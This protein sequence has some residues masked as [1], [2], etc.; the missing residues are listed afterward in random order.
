M[1]IADCPGAA[2]RHIL[3]SLRE[4]QSDGKR[5]G[6]IAVSSITATANIGSITADASVDCGGDITVTN[7]S[8]STGYI[9]DVTAAAA[10][11]ANISAKLSL[12]AVRAGIS[13]AGDSLCSP[14][15][16]KQRA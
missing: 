15:G 4:T 6:R 7:I 13:Q 5:Y 14:P 8:T 16:H 9:G 11:S 2:W 12:G 1:L 10:L 3:H